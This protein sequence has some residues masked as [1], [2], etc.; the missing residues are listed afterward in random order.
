MT[1]A[2]G[3]AVGQLIHQHQRGLSG[4]QTIKVHFFKLHPAIFRAQQGVLRQPV[5]QRLSLGPAMGFNHT[6]QQC[7]PLAQLRMCRLQ[8]G[9]G[10]AHARCRA[11][12]HFEPATPCAWQIS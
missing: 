3:V 9:V 8:H 6:G 2:G 11:Q 12:K 7:D 4:E 10:L 1:T 5:E